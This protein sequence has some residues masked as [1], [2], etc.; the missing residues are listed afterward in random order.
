MRT[1]ITYPPGELLRRRHARHGQVVRLGFG[2]VRYVY[3]LG[4]E[5]NRFVFANDDL[6]EMREAFAG[7]VPVDG[8][9]SLIVSEGPGPVPRDHGAERGR[10]D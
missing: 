3:L 4:P 5:A 1:A 10:G 6:F 7:L 2:A 8:E 9:T